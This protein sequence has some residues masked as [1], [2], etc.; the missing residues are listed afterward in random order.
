MKNEIENGDDYRN[1][2]EEAE[3]LKLDI[4]KFNEERVCIPNPNDVFH[5]TC[6]IVKKLKDS[7]KFYLLQFLKK[8]SEETK[9]FEIEEILP[10]LENLN[11]SHNES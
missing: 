6:S 11:I 1:I 9:T 7:N 8:V 10:N 5:K 2:E 3:K 4:N